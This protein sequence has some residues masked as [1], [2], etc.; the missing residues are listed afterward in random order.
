MKSVSDF[1]KYR[2]SLRPCEEKLPIVCQTVTCAVQQYRCQGE[3][4]CISADWLCDGIADCLDQSD[5]RNCS[6]GF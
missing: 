5:E 3:S 6:G 4:K 1:G 2:W